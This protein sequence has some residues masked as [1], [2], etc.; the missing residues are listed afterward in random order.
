M[1][2]SGRFLTLFF[3]FFFTF[4]I[5]AQKLKRVLFL[6]NSYTAFNNLPVLVADIALSK[7]DTL[8]YDRNTPGGSTLQGHYFNGVSI[9][10]IQQGNWDYVVLQEQSQGPSFNDFFVE[11]NIIFYTKRL[12]SIRNLADSCGETMFYMTW[13]RKNGDQTNCPVNPPSCTYASMQARLRD[14]YLKMANR[15]NS[16]V[17]PV[18]IAWRDTRQHHPSIE[19]Y[20]PDESHPSLAGSYLAACTF[21]AS[22]FHKSPI[23]ATMPG[24]L[25]QA[26]GDSLQLRAHHAVFDSLSVWNI[27][28]TTLFANFTTTWK[29]ARSFLFDG[30]VRGADTAWWDFGDNSRVAFND[31]VSHSFLADGIYLVTLNT[32]KGCDFFSHEFNLSIPGFIGLKEETGKLNP[33]IYAQN[34]ILS[35]RFREPSS[36]PRNLSIYASSGQQVTHSELSEIDNKVNISNI[37]KGVYIV[38]ITENGS[39]FS[40]KIL[41]D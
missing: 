2:W 9:P 3:L 30:I 37:P 40:Q 14:S 20:T 21:Y 28:T 35:I 26:V 4:S 7:G 12:D 8:T 39:L 27:D 16:V 19:L 17:S 24:G 29:G 22:I 10:K 32:Q 25:P 31:T 38:Y 23:G 33:K 15:T 13:G 6:G 36:R 1:I 41:V 5:S 34:N 18:G 11:N